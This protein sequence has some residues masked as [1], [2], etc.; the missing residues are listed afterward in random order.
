MLNWSQVLVYP[1]GTPSDELQYQVS[2][3]IPVGW[4]SASALPV[5]RA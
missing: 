5:D 1:K 3:R 2:L 4:K